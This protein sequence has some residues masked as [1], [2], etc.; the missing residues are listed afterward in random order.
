MLLSAFTDGG[1]E[2]RLAGPAGEHAAP[3]L[4]VVSSLPTVGVEI[5]FKKLKTK[6]VSKRMKWGRLGS[7]VMKR[8][9]SAQGVTLGSR[10]RVLHWAPCMEPASPSAWVSASLSAT[11]MSK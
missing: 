2:G 6:I 8:L 11:L 9:P 5:I 4:R 7:S 10:D 3:D 1:T